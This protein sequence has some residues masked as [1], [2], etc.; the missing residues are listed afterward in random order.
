MPSYVFYDHIYVEFV[1]LREMEVLISFFLPIPISS[2]CPIS[3]KEG[4]R[5][6]DV[7]P[8]L[9]H[10]PRLCLLLSVTCIVMVNM[11]DLVARSPFLSSVCDGML[12]GTDRSLISHEVLMINLSTMSPYGSMSG[13]I[14]VL[15]VF[16]WDYMTCYFVSVVYFVYIGP[17]ER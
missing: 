10:A 3:H 16:H 6:L 7:Y 2:T 13:R 4:L 8:N 9:F 12:P 5:L 17:S 14:F 11:R 1:I 15:F